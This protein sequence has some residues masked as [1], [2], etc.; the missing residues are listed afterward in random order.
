MSWYNRSHNDTRKRSWF[1]LPPIEKYYVVDSG[2]PFIQGFLAPYKLSRN[3]VVRYYMFQFKYGPAP[4]N[5]EELFNRYHASL[6]SV[7]E[8]TFGV[9]KK[10]W[11][12]TCDFSRYSIN[13]QKRVIM[14]TIRLHN[15]IKISIF[16]W[17]RF[18]WSHVRDKRI[19]HIW[20][21]WFSYWCG[22]CRNTWGN[23]WMTY[24]ANE[25]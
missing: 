3:I 19:Q 21:D 17:C 15:F 9:L 6:R 13:I 4:R 25:R 5:K 12:I 8:R 14:A 18:C 2:Y 11:W 1:P 16:F 23:R 7:I 20:E 22:W 24:V 10:K